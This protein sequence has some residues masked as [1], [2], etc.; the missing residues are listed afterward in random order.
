MH[1]CKYFTFINLTDPNHKPYAI[2]SN[3]R[4]PRH[5][6]VKS[7]AQSHTAGKRET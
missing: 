6:E 1:S 5:R 4:K 2:H 7:P 3:I